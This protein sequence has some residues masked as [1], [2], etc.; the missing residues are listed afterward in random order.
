M[1]YQR[2]ILQS[3]QVLLGFETIF[4]IGLSKNIGGASATRFFN[5]FIRPHTGETQFI[6]CLTFSITQALG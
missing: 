3:K 5:L 6:L 4:V 1:Q 2:T